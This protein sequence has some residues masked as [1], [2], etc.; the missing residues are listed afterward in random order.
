MY[1]VAM[2]RFRQH[3][4]RHEQRRDTNGS[5]QLCGGIICGLGGPRRRSS[6][7]L[8]SASAA[9]CGIGQIDLTSGLG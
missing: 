3:F 4:E 5:R 9:F 8:S 6:A 1:T 7:S 2:R